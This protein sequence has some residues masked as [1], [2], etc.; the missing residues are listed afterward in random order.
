[1]VYKWT[2]FSLL[3][4]KWK[5]IR[6][7][8]TFISS[9]IVLTNEISKF[10]CLSV[11]YLLMHYLFGLS[12]CHGCSSI[13]YNKIFIWF[14]LL[15][16][17]S[18]V[19]QW[20]DAAWIRSCAFSSASARH[21][22]AMSTTVCLQ[23]SKISRKTHSYVGSPLAHLRSCLKLK[24]FLFIPFSLSHIH[25]FKSIIHLNFRFIFYSLGYFLFF[26]KLWNMELIWWWSDRMKI[27]V[28]FWYPIH[29]NL[30]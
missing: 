9:F 10:V 25:T 16:P 29:T 24:T 30:L 3:Q 5:E 23:L 1:M 26:F 22:D 12:H 2:Y 6:V 18:D 28:S 4:K 15:L 11:C 27:K 21:A 14:M 20:N 13:A 17:N 7:H 8:P 19:T